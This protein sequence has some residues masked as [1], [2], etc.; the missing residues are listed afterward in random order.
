[1]K[2]DDDLCRLLFDSR[3]TL[4]KDMGLEIQHATEQRFH[5]WLEDFMS[6][7]YWSLQDFWETIGDHFEV[8]NE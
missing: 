7:L 6:P 8:A 3:S 4:Q 1:M 2:F 5:G